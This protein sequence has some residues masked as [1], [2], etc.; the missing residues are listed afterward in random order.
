MK[1]ESDKNNALNDREQFRDICIFL[2]KG[3]PKKSKFLDFKNWF[4]LAVKL[5]NMLFAINIP[6]L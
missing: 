2:I 5:G 3:H 4:T 1:T 6:S